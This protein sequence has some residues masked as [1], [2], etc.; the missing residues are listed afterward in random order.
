M[1]SV[2]C[3]VS[4]EALPHSVLYVC[5]CSGMATPL[6]MIRGG[7][8]AAS[9]GVL[10]RTGAAFQVI[11]SI[12]TI[13][14]DKTGTLTEGKPSVVEVVCPSDDFLGTLVHI[15]TSVEIESQHPLARAVTDFGRHSGYYNAAST[16]TF[17]K[18][19][20]VPGLGVRAV[21][22]GSEILVGSP[23]FLES[24]GV[25]VDEADVLRLGTA[26][27]TLVCVADGGDYLGMFGISDALKIDAM[28]TIAALKS[29][30]L[31]TVILSGDTQA[32]AS[33]IG[34]ELGVDEVVGGL[35][36]QSKADHIRTLQND[37]TVRVAMVGDGTND[38]PALAQADVG[39]ACSSGTDVAIEA[40]DVV[41]VNPHRLS[42]VLDAF[43]VAE[44]TRRK[45]R[46]N[47]TL[48]F[49]FNGTGI[50]AAMTGLLHPVFAMVAMAASVSVIL[51][52]S[53]GGRLLPK[54][55][56]LRTGSYVE[57]TYH[58][59]TIQCG[60]CV[61]TLQSAFSA[62]NGVLTVRP[63]SLFDKTL[64]VVYQTGRLSPE[65]VNAVFLGVKHRAELLETRVVD[66]VDVSANAADTV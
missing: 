1:L 60:G 59:P 10:M 49:S 36:P 26:G 12:H 24:E 41:L 7:G 22:A 31:R 34:E 35:T 5:V 8:V 46:Q 33:R 14:F 64:T 57:A 39:I 29:S 52:N 6:A 55:P 19:T 28:D 65:E 23:R 58:V 45:T 61:A 25:P 30:G 20:A 37:G 47:V 56:W 43:S 21:S 9:K 50:P 38:A 42:G 53:L 11:P 27:L 51:L 32:A 16:L 40:A 48:A 62:V 66:T 63:G 18:V 13:V 44:K 4:F 2:R 17:E 54:L 3:N 15:A